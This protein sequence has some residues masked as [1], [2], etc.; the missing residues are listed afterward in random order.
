[1]GANNVATLSHSLVWFAIGWVA[2][3]FG[4]ASSALISTL[5]VLPRAVLLLAGGELGDRFGPRRMMVVS[6]GVMCALLVGVLVVTGGETAELPVL[7]VLAVGSGVAIAVQ[8]PAQGA[9]PRLFVGDDLLPRAMAQHSSVQQLARVAGPA[10]GGV[11]LIFLTLSH[12]LIIDVVVGAGLI[13]VLALLRPPREIRP[14]GL[15]ANPVRRVVDALGAIARIPGLLALLLAVGLLAASVLPLLY[16]GVPLAAR[17]RGWSPAQAG[18]VEAAW[19]VG[20]LTVT[21]G[22][23]KF[24]VP[25]RIGPWLVIGPLLASAGI[26]VLTTTTPASWAIIGSLVMGGGTAVFTCTAMPLFVAQ[27]PPGMLVRCQAVLALAQTWPLLVA[28]GGFAWLTDLG[29]VSYGFG[30]AALLCLTSGLACLV[31]PSL[32]TA[33]AEVRPS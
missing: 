29:G 14:A 25:T 8:M 13:V 16:L 7:I 11:L 23:A 1:M 12:L 10:L 19:I 6:S 28:N 3:G 27:T 9:L 21:L 20:T 18:L 31:A 4:P 5:T 2:A 17:E 32:R 30:A 22:V 15:S 26:L 24:G 33:S